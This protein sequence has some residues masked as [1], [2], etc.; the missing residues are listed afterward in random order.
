MTTALSRRRASPGSIALTAAVTALIARKDLRDRLIESL[1]TAG[2]AAAEA[3]VHTYEGTVKPLAQ[4][5]GSLVQDVAQS[6]LQEG[7]ERLGQLREG[8]ASLLQSG[9]EGAQS[10]AQQAVQSAQGVAQQAIHGVQAAVG[11]QAVQGAKQVARAGKAVR[12]TRREL[13]ARRSKV[14]KQARRVAD[15]ATTQAMKRMAQL[16]AKLDLQTARPQTDAVAST[17]LTVG[18]VGVSAYLLARSPAVRQGILDAVRSV[19]PQAADA[20]H[21]GGRQIRNIIGTVWLERTEPDSAPAPAAPRGGQGASA[22]AS[23]EPGSDAAKRA[24][25]ER[26]Q[27]QASDTQKA[28]GT[29]APADK[30]ASD[31]TKH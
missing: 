24:E 7:G 20:L 31:P 27:A 16:E 8:G 2:E 1:R 15:K 21:S 28:Q 10:V 11:Q 26:P 9:L 19:S 5:T 17:L 4:D 18:I 14:E 25:G 13:D 12:Q 6:A 23:P 3:A 30:P 22:Y 29:P